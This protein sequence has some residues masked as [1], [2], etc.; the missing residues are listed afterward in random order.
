MRFVLN[1]AKLLN[2]KTILFFFILL[3]SCGKIRKKRRRRKPWNFV[4]IEYRFSQTLYYYCQ[5]NFASF[6]QISGHSHL[7][8][9]I[10]TLYP[11]T[12]FIWLD[13]S[14]GII[15]CSTTR[16]QKS[17]ILESGIYR[18]I[19]CNW[20]IFILC[21][22]ESDI[23]SSYALKKRARLFRI[24]LIQIKLVEAEVSHF[25]V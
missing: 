6:P 11:I 20:N 7:N 4:I 22:Y 17:S 3:I 19:F 13:A 5:G 2:L 15:S 18:L 25:V 10:T 8:P 12:S 9:H 24:K 14:H 16:P 21:R 23:I 1:R